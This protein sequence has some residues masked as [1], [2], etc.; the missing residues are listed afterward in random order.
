M[1]ANLKEQRK[2]AETVFEVEREEPSGCLVYDL[3]G[4]TDEEIKIV[5]GAT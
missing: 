5:E 3:Y 1:K 2:W 4:L